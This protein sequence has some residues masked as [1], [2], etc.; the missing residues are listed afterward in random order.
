MTQPKCRDSAECAR[1]CSS[2]CC[3]H[4]PDS[5]DRPQVAESGSSRSA[6]NRTLLTPQSNVRSRQPIHPT[7][8]ALERRPYPHLCRTI[9]CT[10]FPLSQSL[11]NGPLSTPTVSS[12]TR[13][14][15]RGGLSYRVARHPELERPSSGRWQALPLFKSTVSQ[16]GVDVFVH[17]LLDRTHSVQPNQKIAH[18]VSLPKSRLPMRHSFFQTNGPLQPN[19]CGQFRPTFQVAKS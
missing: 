14:Q 1:G 13:Y 5:L 8:A 17:L 16:G 2:T 9:E 12:F 19:S 18:A 3:R 10:I 6:S 11:A 15:R 4:S 7:G